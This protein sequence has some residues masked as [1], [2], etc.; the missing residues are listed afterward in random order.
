MLTALIADGERRVRRVVDWTGGEGI[1]PDVG[2]YLG[3]LGLVDDIAD[4]TDDRGTQGEQGEPG[5]IGLNGKSAY[6]VAVDNGFV[7]TEPEWLDAY[8]NETAAAATASAIEARDQSEAWA[9]SPADVTP[10]NP[11]AKTSAAIATAKALESATAAAAI[12]VSAAAVG[13]Y[14]NAAAANVPRRISS[15]HGAITPGAGGTNGTFPL[16]FTGGNFAIN[17]TGEFDVVGGAVSA[18]RVTGGG[19]YIGAAPA[20]PAP[21]FA[22]SAGLAG[23]GVVLVTEFSASSG[24]TYWALSADGTYYQLYQNNSGAPLAVAGLTERVMTPATQGGV[25][26]GAAGTGYVEQGKV[27]P[28]IQNQLNKAG[29]IKLLAQQPVV[30]PIIAGKNGGVFLGMRLSDGAAIANIASDNPGVRKAIDQAVAIPGSGLHNYTGADVRKPIIAGRNGGVLMWLDT[31]INP[32]S[33]SGAFTFAGVQYQGL[34]PNDARGRLSD[35]AA[36]A[37]QSVDTLRF[38][39]PVVDGN[40]FEHCAPGARVGYITTAQY[41]QIDVYWNNLVTRLDTYNTV[42]AILV[43]GVL[44]TTFSSAF[45]PGTPGYQSYTFDFGSAAKRKVEIIWCLSAGMELRQTRFSANA[46]LA[47]ASARPNKLLNTHGDSTTHGLGVSSIYEAWAFGL[48][49]DLGRQLLNT[50]N[51]SNIAV[52]AQG[53]VVGQAILDKGIADAKSFY[54]I[55]INDCITNRVPTVAFKTAVEGYIAGFRSKCPTIPLVICSPFYC[56]A[57]E[58]AH[59]FPM[60]DYRDVL[61]AIVIAAVDPNLT[62]VNGKALMVNSP[63]RLAGDGTHPSNL[64]ASEIRTNLFPSF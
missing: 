61:Q 31:T 11:S 9:S 42:C 21:S 39:R 15:T 20:A 33:L 23:A 26:S 59:T 35:Y 36:I 8:V 63:D 4:G 10:G 49:I 54:S 29:P 19:L 58:T 2:G 45:A 53:A 24:Q 34:F 18:V 28:A 64:G 55:G 57:H 44:N 46:A 3:P 14:I 12:S 43:D 60:Q 52:A 1:K 51:G 16:A 50:G 7:G 25:S 62:Y 38:L 40:H 30:Q 41:M 56:P 13:K 6:Q 27:K 5:P 17:P 32:P 48:S 37:E 22:A 47:P